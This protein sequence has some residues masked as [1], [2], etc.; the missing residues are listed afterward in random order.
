MTSKLVGLPDGVHLPTA[1]RN[2]LSADLEFDMAVYVS[3]AQDASSVATLSAISA[4]EAK[5]DA[6]AAAATAAAPTDTLVASLVS[7]TG[8]DSRIALDSVFLGTA[9]LA[10]ASLSITGTYAARPTATAVPNGTVYYASNVPEAYR[11][12]GAT[13]S[14]I[15]SGGNELGYAQITAMFTTTSTTPVYATGLTVTFIVGER[16]VEIHMEAALTN[17]IAA[18]ETKASLVLDGTVVGWMQGVPG[19][20]SAWRQHSRSVRKAGLTPGS[21]HTVQVQ[22]ASTS[23]SG[24][25][26]LSGD[27]TSPSSLSVVTR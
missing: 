16:P 1:V 23:G 26:Y 15:Q 12:N 4:V 5:N 14:V 21:T 22:L 18:G 8:S 7:D 6:E 3:D 19:T 13:W 9:A 27:L 24:T 17:S 2:Q 25:A 10:L 11:S 20:A